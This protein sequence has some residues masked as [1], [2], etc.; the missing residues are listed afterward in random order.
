[1]L[2]IGAD[3]TERAPA[4]GEWSLRQIA[5]HTV[6]ADVGFFVVVKY[7]LDR[8][9]SGDGR[10]AKIPDE[11]W[12]AIIGE[13]W[14]SIEAILGGPLASIQPQ[15]GIDRSRTATA[16]F[17]TPSNIKRM[18]KSSVSVSTPWSGYLRNMIPIAR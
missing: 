10:P 6:G 13:D 15:F 14:A 3:E 16:I 1:M 18:A 7:A 8:H 12:E 4:E 11:A 17:I 9:R 5:A 2:G